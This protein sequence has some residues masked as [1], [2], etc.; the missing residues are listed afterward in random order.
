[1]AKRISFVVVFLETQA[2]YEVAGMDH[3]VNR[4]GHVCSDNVAQK[5]AHLQTIGVVHVQEVSVS[6]VSADTPFFVQV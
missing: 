1:M 6:V 4:K 2:A 3:L 5:D